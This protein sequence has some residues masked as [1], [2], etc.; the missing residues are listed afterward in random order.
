MSQSEMMTPQQV[1]EHLQVKRGSAIGALR[2]LGCPWIRIQGEQWRVRR[3]DLEAAIERA[4][5][6]ARVAG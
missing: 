3:S 6:S 2:A 4:V 5:E 1:A